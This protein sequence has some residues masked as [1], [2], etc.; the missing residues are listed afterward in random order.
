M[1]LPDLRGGR[2]LLGIR[3]RDSLGSVCARSR[4]LRVPGHSTVV[5]LAAL[6]QGAGFVTRSESQLGLICSAGCCR[7]LFLLR[8]VSVLAVYCCY[9]AA[10]CT[11][12]LGSLLLAVGQGAQT[13][14][15]AP[16][17]CCNGSTQH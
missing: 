12:V 4:R 15:L 3:C 7:R 9:Y 17:L 10:L 2:R 1:Q 14:T 8:N 6:C 11:S 5:A 13:H 16:L